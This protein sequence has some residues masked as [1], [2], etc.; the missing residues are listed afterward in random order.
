V[1]QSQILMTNFQMLWFE[2]FLPKAL[3]LVFLEI[4]IIC[5]ALKALFL[6]RNRINVPFRDNFA[7]INFCYCAALLTIYFLRVR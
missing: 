2:N 6:W 5:L 4:F 7:I 3:E 1:L